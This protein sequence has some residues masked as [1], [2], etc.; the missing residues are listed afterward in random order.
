MTTTVYSNKH[1]S[2]EEKIFNG[3]NNK[4]LKYNYMKVSETVSILP[5]LNNK[6]I[7]IEKQFRHVLGRYLYELPAGHMEKNET[8]KQAAGRELEEET[9]YKANRIRFMFKA[10]VSPGLSTELLHY[11]IADKL[12]K[13]K[14]NFDEE[15]EIETIEVTF[16]E[17]LE[18]IKNNEIKNN[19]TITSIF[20]YLQFFKNKI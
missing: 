12:K 4:K 7:I 9:G 6:K 16:D 3:R 18:M 17:I 19:M 5:I 1:F 2:I 8:P 11:F 13:T 10:F 15:E 14:T 20:F